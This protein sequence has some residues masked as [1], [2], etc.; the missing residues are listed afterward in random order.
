MNGTISE[1][2]NAHARWPTDGS[3]RTG[4]RSTANVV[5][6]KEAGGAGQDV[7]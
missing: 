3:A 4:W 5:G 7:A 1:A 2:S 6:R